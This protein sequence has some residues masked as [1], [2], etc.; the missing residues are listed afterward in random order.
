MAIPQTSH[1]KILEQ[2]GRGGMG[3]VYRAYDT[4]LERVVA[5]KFLAP[6]FLQDPAE[7]A[8]LLR[9]ARAAAG[10]D[11]PNICTVY[12]IEEA[13]DQT[14]IVMTWVEGCTLSQK[15]TAGPL[16]PEEAVRIALQIAEGLAAAH[17]SG[18]V[19]RD[20]KSANIMITPGGNIKITD[21]GL[22]M[23]GQS[24]VAAGT[25]RTLGTPAYVAPEQIHGEK[26][27][28]RADIWAC[29][30]VLYE[31][32]TGSL[33]FHGANEHELIYAILADAPHPMPDHI[34]P[35]L[36][37]I[38]ERCLQKDP[39]QRFQ[40]ATELAEALRQVNGHGRAGQE[41]AQSAR[42]H[43]RSKWLRALPGLFA[44]LLAFSLVIL[45][46][47]PEK[48]SLLVLDFLNETG[49]SGLDGLSGML[50][51]ALEP[52]RYLRVV[53]RWRLLDLLEQLELDTEHPVDE[54]VGRAV[55]QHANMDLL[56]TGVVRKLAGRYAIEIIVHDLRANTPVFSATEWAPAR[57]RVPDLIDRLAIRIRM[58]FHENAEDIRA[59]Q[60][61]VAEMTTA[62]LEAYQDYF[63]GEQLLNRMELE[64]AKAA[65]RRAIARD[66]LFALAYY[67]LAYVMAW[68]LG[69]EQPVSAP[70]K[71]AI[72]L[73]DRL[74]AQ[75]RFLL[76]AEKARIEHG[77][78]AYLQVLKQMEQFYPDHKEML[79]NIGDAYTH[80][81][82]PQKAIPYFRRVVE[83][84]PTFGRA[85][86]HLALLYRDLEQYP[87]ALAYAKRY[88]SVTASPDAYFLLA[89][90]Y[91]TMRDYLA[92]TRVLEE[93]ASLYPENPSITV[94]L[95][96]MLFLQEKIAEGIHLLETL[97]DRKDDP[98]AVFWGNWGLAFSYPYQGRYRDALLASER[99][100]AMHQQRQDTLGMAILQVYRGL[101][102]IWGWHDTRAAWRQAQIT[103]SYQ[104]RVFGYAYWLGYIMLLAYHGDYE[105]AMQLARQKL[106]ELH[107]LAP[108]ILSLQGQPEAAQS[109]VDQL[110]PPDLQYIQLATL[111]VLAESQLRAGHLDAARKNLLKLQQIQDQTGGFRAALLPQSYYLLGRI[112]EQQ[113][114]PARAMAAY[115]KCL[116]F[117][118]HADPDLPALLDAR[119]R[120]QRLRRSALP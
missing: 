40:S 37:T 4:R 51:T 24:A 58:A 91:Q 110:K 88:V 47:S 84:D 28:H 77:M 5:L 99:L 94:A 43:W 67:R 120:L 31:M 69:T 25:G 60:R 113:H 52:A 26:V 86:Q 73:M 81:D 59:S 63:R 17:E 112:F 118:A 80:M 18:I 105:Q 48:K 95:A 29:G 111:F 117:W 115:E 30:V 119:H 72:A 8:R 97:R 55:G 41:A 27:D 107:W 32:L 42:R 78:A 6:E 79:Y 12:A 66:S 106:P 70:L 33:P 101:L 89:Q 96:S 21:F 13:E 83:M 56:A 61:T 75:E 1:Y 15:L 65:Y 23:I 44:L 46:R 16:Q 109:R 92:G 49:E 82:Q 68:Q 102:H 90:I 45:N 10:L 3:V 57:D 103:Q 19:H 54:S 74:P 14:F 64:K 36:R 7:K 53:P 116:S 114:Q 87:Q 38:I 71:K 108:F 39:A 35:S 2:I 9:E 85:L 50:I 76:R 11:H 62:D 20:I 93:A 98:Q 34:P 100:I 22:A 104:H